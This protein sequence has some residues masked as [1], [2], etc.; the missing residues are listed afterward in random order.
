MEN[1][2]KV[3]LLDAS[4]LELVEAD[5]EAVDFIEESV[6]E[7]KFYTLPPWNSKD[8]FIL[9][10]SFCDTVRISKA[11]SDLK[12]VLE[13]GRGVFRNFKN[14]LSL[15]PELERRFNAYKKNYMQTR[16]FEW[17]G[18]LRESWGLESLAQESEE[19]DLVDEDF[20]FS[21]C[22]R[23][24]FSCIEKEADFIAE[25]LRQTFTGELG[26]AFSGLWLRRF[27]FSEADRV[28]G[29]ICRTAAGEFAGA[30]L[31]SSDFE[32][33][34]LKKTVFLTALFVNQNYRGLGI[35]GGL[36]KRLSSLLK[37]AGIHWLIF[38]GFSTDEI[39]EPLLK[40]NGFKKIGSNFVLDLED[41]RTNEN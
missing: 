32:K 25:E 9:L 16:V 36:I 12:K 41:C 37:A 33:N 6:G 29:I 7:E 4:S 17:Y 26:Q 20:S 2:Q 34:G 30:A 28:N 8:G 15:Y 39:F 19:I 5:S 35:A 10:E 14:A 22:S 27:D 1:Q 31:Y 21:E 11:R 3:F 18:S 23:P 38:T 24:D 40:A 13:E